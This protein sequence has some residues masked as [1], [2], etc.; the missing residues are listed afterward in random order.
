MWI[1]LFVATLA[2]LSALGLAPSPVPVRTDEDR[3]PY[4]N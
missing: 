2:T 4:D 1:V 3:N